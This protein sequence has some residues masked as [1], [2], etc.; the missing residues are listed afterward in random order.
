MSNGN[1]PLISYWDSLVEVVI[2]IFRG[3]IGSGALEGLTVVAQNRRRESKAL[4]A[5]A[6]ANDSCR[7]DE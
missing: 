1:G 5:H 4:P 7:K 3:R 6:T 2:A